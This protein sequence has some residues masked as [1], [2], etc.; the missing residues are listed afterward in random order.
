MSDGLRVPAQKFNPRSGTYYAIS[1]VTS[2]NFSQ[3]VFYASRLGTALRCRLRNMDLIREISRTS[4]GGARS[5]EPCVT[6]RVLSD[7][8]GISEIQDS[9]HATTIHRNSVLQQWTNLRT[10]R[11]VYGEFT[12]SV[13]Q[14]SICVST[15]S[16]AAE[17]TTSV[18][19]RSICQVSK[20]WIDRCF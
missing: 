11:R 12:H 5:I 7:M 6:L 14:V 10:S 19:I 15:S 2:C 13:D 9:D 8:D 16:S 1:C 4:A 3:Q 17:S 20:W 18:I